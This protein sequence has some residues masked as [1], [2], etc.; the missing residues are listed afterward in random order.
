V[1]VTK[2][3][4]IGRKVLQPRFTVRRSQKQLSTPVKA[5]S[6][7]G[8]VGRLEKPVGEPG[9]AN[10]H[11]RFDERGVETGHGGILGHRQPKGP[12]TRKATPTPPRHS[13]TLPDP[14]DLHGRFGSRVKL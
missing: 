11:A 9:A 1:D 2:S 7:D 6:Q 10:P 14:R 13:S 5:L 3:R 12:A 4:G 8:T